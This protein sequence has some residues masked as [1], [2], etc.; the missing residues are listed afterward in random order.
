MLKKNNGRIFFVYILFSFGILFFFQNC[1]TDNGTKSLSSEMG[2]NGGGYQGKIVGLFY[3]FIPNN[4]CADKIEI[5][6]Q[7][8]TID[9]NELSIVNFNKKNCSEESSSLNL[10]NVL[11]S[12]FQ[13]EVV[14]INKQIFVKYEERPIQIP[15]NLV[16]VLC[17]DQFEK[18]NFEV[19]IRFD[20][21]TQGVTANLYSTKGSSVKNNLS[22][23]LSYDYVNYQSEN[24]NLNL[25]FTQSKGSIE[26]IHQGEITFDS[27]KKT[28]NCI[29]GGA[30]DTSSWKS[31]LVSNYNIKRFSVVNNRTPF[32]FADVNTKDKT[33]MFKI[34][35]D[36]SVV[37]LTE[38]LLG[39]DFVLLSSLPFSEDIFPF[40]SWKFGEMKNST[41]LAYNDRTQ[42]ILPLYDRTEEQEGLG[43][44]LLGTVIENQISKS[45]YVILPLKNYLTNKI[46]VRVIDT[47]NKKV[48][49]EFELNANEYSNSVILP[50][51]DDVIFLVKE[52]ITNKTLIKFHNLLSQQDKFFT[53]QI[54]EGC[55]SGFIDA[56]SN[57]QIFI[58]NPQVLIFLKCSAFPEDVFLYNLNLSSGEVYKVATNVK[59]NWVSDEKK[60]IYFEDLKI[61]NRKKAF[62]NLETKQIIYTNLKVAPWGEQ[63]ILNNL[64]GPFRKDPWDL[65][66]DII[67][68]MDHV[69]FFDPYNRP[70][71]II[72]QNLE[73]SKTELICENTQGE[74][75]RIGY[76][77]E[78]KIY[79]VKYDHL[80]STFIFY[81]ADLK[82][83]ECRYLNQI[84]SQFQFIETAMRTS[85]GFTISLK[86]NN[87]NVLAENILVPIDGRPPLKLNPVGNN[88]YW[89]ISVDSFKSRIFLTGPEN[90]NIR[91][92][93]INLF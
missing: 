53:T 83:K 44:F 66:N 52:S 32:F 19:I 80:T 50:N 6:K 33:Q 11:V 45:G 22:R 56:N 55:N 13:N 5:P 40:I 4:F 28:L 30:L 59:I 8:A 62:Y 15:N 69:V 31:K 14:A 36:D 42:D 29:I 49:E 9:F 64:L 79:V 46:T 20:R 3:N 18:P 93:Q 39:T 74:T 78:N 37:N 70:L 85:L 84:N 81:L 61:I 88:S 73:N 21:E 58:H 27:N 90:E 35:D 89:S 54:P 41:I 38:K 87:N 24:L 2:G 72:Y 16:E 86:E 68:N 60:W 48:T 91:L 67:Y 23:I 77:A 34:L 7:L 51:T 71:K 17:R 65:R 82:S 75:R 26:Q 12:Q 25:K 63:N 76:F 57:N 43:G 47:T 1:K 92:Y 10:S